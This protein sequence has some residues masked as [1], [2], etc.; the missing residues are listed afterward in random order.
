MR[1]AAPQRLDTPGDARFAIFAGFPAH[2]IGLR[3]VIRS[4]MYF[5]KVAVAF[6]SL[7]RGIA[8]VADR[9]GHA[10]HA[11][12]CRCVPNGSALADDHPGRDE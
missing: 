8:R 12:R 11:H 1:C 10:R 2:C 6:E 7:A 4:V 3:S 9:R 5:D